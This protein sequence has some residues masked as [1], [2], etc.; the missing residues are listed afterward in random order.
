M[1]SFLLPMKIVKIINVFLW[2]SLEVGISKGHTH[3]IRLLAVL[4]WIVE[5]ASKYAISDRSGD[6]AKA[7]RTERALGK[8]QFPLGSF[9]RSGLAELDFVISSPA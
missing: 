2:Y 9:S 3:I 5:R 6:R 7:M 4:F 8:S 1:K